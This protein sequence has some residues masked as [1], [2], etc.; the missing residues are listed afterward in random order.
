MPLRRGEVELAFLVGRPHDI[1][2]LHYH[3]RR[4]RSAPSSCCRPGTGWRARPRSSCGELDGE[5]LAG[6]TG[7]RWLPEVE[8][9]LAEAGIGPVAG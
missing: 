1:D 2:D 7:C 5:A 4:H 8:E 3:V 9:R 6:W